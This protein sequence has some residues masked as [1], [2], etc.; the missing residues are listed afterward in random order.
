M[1]FEKYLE[2]F[3]QDFDALLKERET[4]DGKIE[5]LGAMI[6]SC[7]RLLP[8]SEL[9]APIPVITSRKK[10]RTKVSKR[11]RRDLVPDSGKSPRRKSAAEKE[12]STG[13]RLRRPPKPPELQTRDQKTNRCCDC[14]GPC[15]P[16]GLR[17]RACSLKFRALQR[18]AVERT[19]EPEPEVFRMH[20]HKAER[21]APAKKNPVEA[22]AP[23]KGKA[24]C[25]LCSIRDGENGLKFIAKQPD[26]PEHGHLGRETDGPRL[27]SSLE[28]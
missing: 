27:A 28:G 6:E 4:I 9:D 3:Q 10:E 13:G 26:C 5:A 19:P 7:K 16:T 11:V 23:E 8:H 2:T 15:S 24:S 22:V 12:P 18:S 20:D 17:C 21:K 14:D 25:G 1:N